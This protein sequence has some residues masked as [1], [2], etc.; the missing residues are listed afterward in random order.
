MLGVLRMTLTKMG[1]ISKTPRMAFQKENC[2]FDASDLSEIDCGSFGG[3]D[4]GLPM[5]MGISEGSQCHAI[6]PSEQ[7][8]GHLC[9]DMDK[10]ILCN[11]LVELIVSSAVS[12]LFIHKA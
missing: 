2:I 11:R 5:P 3:E 12:S 9:R 4:T 8:G 6:Q 10:S 7:Y 1:T